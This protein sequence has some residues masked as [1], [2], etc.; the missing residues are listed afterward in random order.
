MVVEA[1]GSGYGRMVGVVRNS[2]GGMWRCDGG[3][4]GGQRQWECSLVWELSEYKD[5]VSLR[6]AQAATDC[7]FVGNEYVSY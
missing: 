4:S 3:G 6:L 5:G 7:R 2:K 1:A